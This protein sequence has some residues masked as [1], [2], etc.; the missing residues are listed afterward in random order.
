MPTPTCLCLAI[1]SMDK[2]ESRNRSTSLRSKMR[3]GRPMAFPLFAT[4]R[5]VC[6]IPARHPLADHI[7]DLA[8][9]SAL[10]APEPLCRRRV[11][12]AVTADGKGTVSASGDGTLNVWDLDSD[13]PIATFHCDGPPHCLPARRLAAHRCRRRGRLRVHPFAGAVPHT[14]GDDD[15]KLPAP[16]RASAASSGY[17]KHASVSFHRP[18][19]AALLPCFTLFAAHRPAIHLCAPVPSAPGDRKTSREKP[20]KIT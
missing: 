10:R 18:F 1:R 13:L 17:G 8:T 14:V 7:W 4:C 9:G 19:P 6:S 20:A 16:D 2:P 3:F 12:V 15:S 5:R 11:S